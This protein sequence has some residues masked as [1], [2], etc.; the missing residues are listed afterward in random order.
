MT[1]GREWWGN[2]IF[3]RDHLREKGV[4]FRHTMGVKGETYATSYAWKGK[5]VSHMMKVC[6]K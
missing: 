3:E 5:Q 2:H 6:V 1:F 4:S